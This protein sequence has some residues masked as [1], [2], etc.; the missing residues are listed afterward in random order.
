[1]NL[2]EK[3]LWKVLRKL[4]LHVRRQAPIGRY[5]ADFVC[6]E[7]GLVIEIDG[8][9]HT[10]AERRERDLIRDDWLRSQGYRV[11]RFG[12]QQVLDQLDVVMEAIHQALPL[13][14]EGALYSETSE[15]RR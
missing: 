14:G 15:C 12:N 11:L 13:E 7:I 5:I 2:P 4:D 8:Y 9:P 10:F 3:V 6:H 1:M